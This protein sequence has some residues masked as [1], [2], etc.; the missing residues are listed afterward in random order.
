VAENRHRDQGKGDPRHELVVEAG[1]RFQLSKFTFVQPD[2][3]W[4]SR[5]SG[6]GR[7]PKAI[8]AGAEMGVTF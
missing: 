3:Q 7:I 8:V 5:P 1:Y 4:V 2:L 6:T